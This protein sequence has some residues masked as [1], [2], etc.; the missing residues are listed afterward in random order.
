M[1]AACTH[2]HV[3]RSLPFKWQQLI[4]S[5]QFQFPICQLIVFSVNFSHVLWFYWAFS[6]IA[7]CQGRVWCV[8]EVVLL[9]PTAS[10]GKQSL[11]WSRGPIQ[12]CRCWLLHTLPCWPE[13]LRL[14]KHWLTHSFS[15]LYLKFY[16]KHLA[17]LQKIQM[18]CFDLVAE[19]YET[20]KKSPLTFK[21]PRL[22]STPPQ[23]R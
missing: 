16:K 1:Q 21:S 10:P 14:L 8:A 3:H 22:H 11:L 7:L 13:G 2:L 9:S 23:L 4:N 20:R 18:W 6:S 12:S 5:W 17:I 19:L 15:Q